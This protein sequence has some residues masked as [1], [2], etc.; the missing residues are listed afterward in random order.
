MQGNIITVDYAETNN[1]YSK[2]FDDSVLIH[3]TYV[4]YDCKDDC[5]KAWEVQ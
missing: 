4:Y 5:E 2:N 1:L 3:K